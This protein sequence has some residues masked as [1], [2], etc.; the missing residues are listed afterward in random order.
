M[1]AHDNYLN[2]KVY[3]AGL[4]LRLSRE[5]EENG[6]SMSIKNQKDY[7][8][9]YVLEKGWNIVDIYIDDGFSGLNFDRPAFQNMIK[10]I[11]DKKIDLVITKDLSRLGRDYIETGYYT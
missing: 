11:E 3:N 5:D 2:L 7:L 1:I 9:S 4:Y 10:D 6:Q 8:M